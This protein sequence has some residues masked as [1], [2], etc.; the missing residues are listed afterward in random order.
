MDSLADDYYV[1]GT[2]LCSQ[3][4]T[5]DWWRQTKALHGQTQCVPPTKSELNFK[6][7]NHLMIKQ[8]TP[9]NNVKDWLAIIVLF[10]AW[11]L[12]KFKIC[13]SLIWEPWQT[14]TNAA[15]NLWALRVVDEFMKK[16]PPKSPIK[17]KDTQRYEQNMFSITIKSHIGCPLSNPTLVAYQVDTSFGCI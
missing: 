6:G 1:P 13:E 5:D 14:V 4:V 7:V 3:S 17:Q 16:A 9:P 12:Y 15:T 2:C 10:G 8:W 11:S